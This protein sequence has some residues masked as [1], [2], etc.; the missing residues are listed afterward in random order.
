MRSTLHFLVCFL[1]KMWLQHAVQRIWAVRG[2]D[3]LHGG[4]V[5]EAVLAD[6]SRVRTS[7][8]AQIRM[9]E[10]CP[11]GQ[12]VQQLEHGS[13]NLADPRKLPSAG[14]LLA[15]GVQLVD[16]DDSRCFPR[17]RRSTET[18]TSSFR[19]YHLTLPEHEKKITT[20]RASLLQGRR[21]HGRSSH[22]RR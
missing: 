14:A 6:L 19:S 15:D 8:A 7:D 9:C 12:L 22:H 10:L 17:R 21:H 1:R 20:V 5:G 16:E 2:C 18:Y 3:D 13:L 4:L 11:S